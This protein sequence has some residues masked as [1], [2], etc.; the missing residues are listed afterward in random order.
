MLSLGA[1]AAAGLTMTALGSVALSRQQQLH[2]DTSSEPQQQQARPP[3]A[4]E[5]RRNLPI[6]DQAPEPAVL[7]PVKSPFQDEVGE[8][9]RFVQQ[10]YFTARDHA[11]AASNRWIGIEDTAEAHLKRVVA[12]EESLTPGAFYIAIG[13]LAGSILTKNRNFLLRLAAPPVAF[14]AS[15]AYFMPKTYENLSE[16]Y[17]G[18]EQAHL[19]QLT[20]L[21][22]KVRQLTAS[23]KKD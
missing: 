6:Y 23:S 2:A 9:R 18:F 3:T 20:E 1:K 17:E 7:V 15:T 8:A 12:P 14:V 22:A 19:P 4:A 21:R 11:R 10:A 5:L 13:T 16:R